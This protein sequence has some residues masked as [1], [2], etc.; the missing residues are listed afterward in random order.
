MVGF[1]DDG[2]VELGGGH[3]DLVPVPVFAHVAHCHAP[4]FL[5]GDLVGGGGDGCVYEDLL[6]AL[7]RHN[8]LGVLVVVDVAEVHPDRFDEADDGLGRRVFG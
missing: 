8:E 2:F 6:S 3:D 1:E 5:E 7:V 4:C